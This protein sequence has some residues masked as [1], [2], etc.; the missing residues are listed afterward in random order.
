MLGQYGWV[1]TF[2][3]PADNSTAI[4]FPVVVTFMAATQGI[5]L[6][7]AEY[8]IVLLLSTVAS[9]GTTPIPSSSLV[10]TVMICNSVN[11]PVTG[12]YA[13]VVAIDWFVDR[14]RTALNV[15][16]DLFAAKIVYVITKIEDEP[17][18][19]GTN[20]E[21][22]VEDAVEAYNREIRGQNAL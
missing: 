20:E 1:S 19:G 6:N 22:A 4:Y 13:V 10:L 15:S 5:T 3:I 8:I 21:A 14:F 17:E 12:M 7:P 2:K 18:E 11:V 9:I 16:S